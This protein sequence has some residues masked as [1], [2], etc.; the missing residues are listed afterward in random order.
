M[1]KESHSINFT[2][3]DFTIALIHELRKYGIRSFNKMDIEKE[4][5]HY[6]E[7]YLALFLDIDCRDNRLHLDESIGILTITGEIYDLAPNFDKKYTRGMWELKDGE[8]YQPYYEEMAN[9]VAEYLTRKKV[10]EKFLQENTIKLRIHNIN[11]NKR[12]SLY[13]G[14]LGTGKIITRNL[15]T[16]GEAFLS[17]NEEMEY[18]TASL[19]IPCIRN[20]EWAYLK[21]YQSADVDVRKSSFVAIQGLINNDLITM[22]LYTESIDKS[23]LYSYACAGK[24]TETNRDIQ[25]LS[26]RKK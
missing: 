2:E 3:L 1:I 13:R 20:R 26:L 16:M 17:E 24:A 19:E 11:P 23:E 18:S 7:K 14:S 12:Y 21:Q 22:D 6:R 8:K 25:V 9:L 5:Y 10:E 15:V 4:L